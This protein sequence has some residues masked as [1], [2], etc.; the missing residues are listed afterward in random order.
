M[1]PRRALLLALVAVIGC[2]AE[3]AGGERCGGGARPALTL[4]P[5]HGA[6]YAK[7]SVEDARPGETW[8]LVLVHEGHVVWRGETRVTAH[9]GIYL[10][11][12]LGDYPGAD[13]V[14]VRATG[15]DGATCGATATAEAQN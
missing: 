9:G 6:I 1:L 10:R 13:S 2:G 3:E 7:F 15:P 14:R 5:A 8:R 4:R 11:R 12:K